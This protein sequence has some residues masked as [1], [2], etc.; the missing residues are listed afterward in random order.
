MPFFRANNARSKAHSAEIYAK[1]ARADSIE[2]R[3]S[4][5]SAAPDFR[6]PGKNKIVDSNDFS[7]F[8]HSFYFF[9]TGE[10]KPQPFIPLDIDRHVEGKTVISNHTNMSPPNGRL[11]TSSN[12]LPNSSMPLPS[13]LSHPYSQ[14]I[15]TAPPSDLDGGVYQGQS[16]AATSNKTHE[17]NPTNKV[18]DFLFSNFLRNSMLF[19]IIII[20]FFFNDQIRLWDLHLLHCLLIRNVKIT[21][22]I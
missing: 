22:E 5:K 1:Q 8:P 17:W 4:A 21:I 12:Y 9:V 14:P 19:I 16:V 13:H 15:T 10:E 18:N 2:A 3:V 11:P 6:Q 20:F 7:N